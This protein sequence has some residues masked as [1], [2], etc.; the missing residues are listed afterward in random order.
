VDTL[1]GLLAPDAIAGDY[2][3][4]ERSQG[5]LATARYEEGRR[6][7]APLQGSRLVPSSTRSRAEVRPL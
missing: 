4:A 7:T 1:Y 5:A 2:K 3:Q 6:M